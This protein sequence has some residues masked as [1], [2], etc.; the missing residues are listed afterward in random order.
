MKSILIL[1]LAL[2]T[3]LPVKAQLFSRDNLGSAVVGGIL[4]GVIGHNSGR[5]TA[6]G[7]GIGAGTVSSG[8]AA[9]ETIKSS[10]RENDLFSRIAD[11]NAR[12]AG[13]QQSLE[14]T[15]AWTAGGTDA[16]AALLVSAVV[17]AFGGWQVMKGHLTLGALLAFQAILVAFIGPV[18]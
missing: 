10:G 13:S 4:G 12:V 16:L 18:L 15:A 9:I 1:G 2:A 11:A 6:E 5:R 14:G 17:L 8:L 7:I 3:A